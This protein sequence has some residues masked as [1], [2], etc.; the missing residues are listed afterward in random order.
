MYL[1]IFIFELIN[2]LEGP[3]GFSGW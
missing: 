3:S 2:I 1:L